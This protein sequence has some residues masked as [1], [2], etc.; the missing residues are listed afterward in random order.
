[1]HLSGIGHP[2]RARFCRRHRPTLRFEGHTNDSSPSP[3]SPAPWQDP[4]GA[5]RCSTE[6]TPCRCGRRLFAPLPALRRDPDLRTTIS[7]VAGRPIVQGA[8][9]PPGPSPGIW[10]RIDI[11]VDTLF[12]QFPPEVLKRRR[13][14][15]C[16]ARQLWGPI[17]CA[18]RSQMNTFRGAVGHG[19]CCVGVV[20]CLARDHLP[21][22]LPGRPGGGVGL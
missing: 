19:S 20:Q 16:L 15:V 4:S 2:I 12:E 6:I 8:P 10:S 21:G 9:R 14:P 17:C 13:R 7:R 3:G 11:E 1:M 22:R 5:S 18:T